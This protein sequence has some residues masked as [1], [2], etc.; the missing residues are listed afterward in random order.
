MK[1]LLIY[2][3]CSL[4]LVTAMSPAYAV[5]K[6]KTDKSKTNQVDKDKSS[7]NDSSSIN[8]KPQKKYDDFIDKNQNGVDDRRENLVPKTDEPKSDKSKPAPKQDSTK[9]SPD[10]KK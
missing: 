7:Q 8:S 3:L 1:R 10:D 5:D 4:F 9:K 6:K 2:L